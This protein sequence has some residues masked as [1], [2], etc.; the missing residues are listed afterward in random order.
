MDFEWD[1]VKPESNVEEH[2]VSF[3]EPMTVFA[4]PLQITIP[5]PDH[6]EDEF[7]FV[8]MVRSERGRLL[9]VAYTEHQGRIRI[10]SAREAASK[11]RRDYERAEVQ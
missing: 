1:V 8:S 7:R 6:S 5:D 10:I 2:G 3:A 4:D 11:E 9:V